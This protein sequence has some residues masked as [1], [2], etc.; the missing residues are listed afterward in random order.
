MTLGDTVQLLGNLADVIGAIA[1]VVTLIYLTIQIRQ[2]TNALHAQSRQ[3]LIAAGQAELFALID[4]P[5]IAINQ[6][7]TPPLTPQECVKLNFWLSA[8]MRAREFAW[9]QY[10]SGVLD[11]IQWRT[12]A[13]VIQHVLAPDNCRTWWESVGRNYFPVEF[14]K[15]VDNVLRASAV[16]IERL[17]LFTNWTNT[18]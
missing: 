12:E 4:H 1:I 3:S 2:N 13:G 15:V 8:V 11:E 18:P 5:D 17:P 7:K 9:L 6:L 10:H 14:V 16:P